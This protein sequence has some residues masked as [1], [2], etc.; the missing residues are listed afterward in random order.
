M[1]LWGSGCASTPY[2]Y[3][4]FHLP[5]PD[6]PAPQPVAFKFG[7]PHKTLDRLG[8]LA[9]V[10]ERV[11]TLNAKASNHQVS[12][13]TLQTLR[14]YMEENDIS[15]VLVAVN[16]YDPKGQWRRLQENDRVAPFWKYSVGTLTWLGY[17]LF[18][19]R[20]FGGDEYNPFTNSLNVTSDVPALVLAE[21]AYAKDIHSQSLPGAYATMNDLPF[22][23]LVRH[24]RATSDILGY[25][26]LHNNWD[27]E[28]EAYHVLYPHVGS[29]TF[30]PVSHF[31]PIV[32]PFMSAGGALVGHAA[33]RTVT[34]VLEPTLIQASPND[35]LFPVSEV[36][37]EEVAVGRFR[38]PADE[39]D[40]AEQGR[41]IPAGFEE[42][43]PGTGR[44]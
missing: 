40:L 22:L 28:K 8:W 18:P 30:G 34:A 10:P 17:T 20:V 13:E 36:A 15:D 29:T 23:S 44:K 12:P 43:R 4:R 16:D 7:K 24:T 33:G 14:V 2:R 11:F 31:V 42:P 1:A 25:A 3:G 21:A 19:Y 38:L 9:G 35:D 41:V 39:Q 5:E 6:G 32:G 26:R 27:G 37:T